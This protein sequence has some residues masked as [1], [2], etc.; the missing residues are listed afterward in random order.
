MQNSVKKDI[1]NTWTGARRDPALHWSHAAPHMMGWAWSFTPTPPHTHLPHPPKK[2]DENAF[3]LGCIFVFVPSSLYISP[4]ACVSLSSRFVTIYFSVQSH[5]A[6]VWEE[7]ARDQFTN[8][9]LAVRNALLASPFKLHFRV[10]LPYS[11]KQLGGCQ[12]SRSGAKI[13]C[14][15]RLPMLRLFQHRDG[16]REKKIM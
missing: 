3:W 15:K 2:S 5:P 7:V 10:W 12:I 4:P 1:K 8:C 11:A 6:L 13:K 9:F 14:Y 16:R